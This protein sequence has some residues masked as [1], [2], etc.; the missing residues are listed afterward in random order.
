MTDLL[1]NQ[2]TDLEAVVLFDFLTDFPTENCPECDRSNAAREPITVHGVSGRRCRS[3]GS[4]WTGPYIRREKPYPARA[5]YANYA[6]NTDWTVVVNAL[7]Q[8]RI[9]RVDPHDPVAGRP[10]LGD[11]PG[12]HRARLKLEKKL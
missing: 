1:M 7:G 4:T 9:R 5:E 6:G 12:C 3:C 11:T 10:R 8:A 2:V